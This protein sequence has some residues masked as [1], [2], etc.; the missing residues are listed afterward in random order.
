MP[1][2]TR[3]W[4]SSAP[5]RGAVGRGVTDLRISSADYRRHVREGTLDAIGIPAGAAVG[6]AHEV[7]RPP[8]PQFD[9][10][11]SEY[12]DEAGFQREVVERLNRYRLPCLWFHVPN[13]GRRSRLEAAIFKGL[14]VKAGVAD[15]IFLWGGGCGCI[16]L[17]AGR[18]SLSDAQRDF[19]A[20]CERLGV[21]YVV[22]RS[23]TDID[24]ALAAWGLIR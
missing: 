1:E 17:K 20:N 6:K 22:A 16:E 21:P 15:F 10:P 13:G 24:A 5:R 7:E 19:R 12:P 23:L 14:G 8:R 3:D 9:A 18:G 11:P 2:P 4:C